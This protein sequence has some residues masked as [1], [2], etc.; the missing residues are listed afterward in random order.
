MKKLFLEMNY[1]PGVFGSIRE[2]E[3]VGNIYI[4]RFGLHS[5][6]GKLGR[7]EILKAGWNSWALAEGTVHR[8]NFYSLCLK[9]A[10]ALFLRP[11]SLTE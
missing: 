6:R 5:C 8:W 1:K 2:A 4:E 7:S 9:E 10:S 11:F 3:P